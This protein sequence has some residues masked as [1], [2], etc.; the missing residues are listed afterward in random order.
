MKK[1]LII[2]ILFFAIGCTKSQ[3]KIPVN[4]LIVMMGESN[5]GGKGVNADLSAKELAPRTSVKIL[6]N[7]TLLFENLDVGTNNLILHQDLADNATNGMEVGMA[8]SADSG[9]L[10]NIPVYI[11]KA[12]TGS[13]RIYWWNDSTFLHGGVN[14]WEQAKTRIDT[15]IKLLT[16]NNAKPAIYLIWSQGLNDVGYIANET[17]WSDSTIIFFAKFRARY[18]NYIPI[19]TTYL[20]ENANPTRILF[21]GKITQMGNLFRV[22]PIVTSDATMI[23]T[24]HW[25]S[26]GLKIIA[27]RI[28]YTLKSIYKYQYQ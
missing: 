5:I 16:I 18:G 6:N 2:F 12:G 3:Q 15:A 23:D 19:F 24:Y 25:S 8:N 10:G 17:L 22:Y 26:A 27:T 13:S 21:N 4:S 1:I 7:N 28:L 9:T 11:L 20:P 14:A